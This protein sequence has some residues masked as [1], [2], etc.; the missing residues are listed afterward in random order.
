MIVLEEVLIIHQILI[1]SYGGGKGVRDKEALLSAI[2]RPYSTFEGNELYPTASEKAAAI[3]ESILI[4]HPFIDGNKRT[5]YVLMRLIL[6]ES[7]FDIDAKEEEKYD[8]VINIASGTWKYDQIFSWIK[9]RV[10]ETWAS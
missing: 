3:I 2:H 5:G 6:L 7:G 8:F 1:N 10:V 4:N 9:D